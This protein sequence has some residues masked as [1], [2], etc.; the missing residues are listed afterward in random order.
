MLARSWGAEF[1]DITFWLVG[2]GAIQKNPEEA[3][4]GPPSRQDCKVLGRRCVS[5]RRRHRGARAQAVG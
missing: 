2:S 3:R 1:S 5:D 4:S